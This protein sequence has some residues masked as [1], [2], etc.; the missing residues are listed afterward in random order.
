VIEV[1]GFDRDRG[2]LDESAH[3]FC[4]GSK[5]DCRLTTRYN[6]DDFTT[7]LFAIMHEAGHG[8]YEQ[9]KPEMYRDQPVGQAQGMAFHES[10][11]LIMECQAGSSFEFIEF[12]AKLLRDD[13]GLNGPC[14]RAE[15]LYNR[16]NR[17]KPSFIRVEA[18]EVSYP[19]HVI[20]RFEIEQA[21]I[22]DKLPARDIPGLWASKMEQYLG[23]V[24]PSDREGCL[25]DVH[26]PAGYIG[27]FP[28][29]TNGAI[30]AS[31]LMHAAQGQHA[32]LRQELASGNFESLN[33]YLNKQLR[34]FGCL[35]SPAQLL[36]ISTGYQTINPTIF[37]DYL[38][39]KYLE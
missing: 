36:E 19:L 28:S 6:E 9:N 2:R 3:P 25:Q 16:I 18:D 15:N 22:N 5:D 1:M 29:Y 21:I 30:I 24:P 32:G 38:R 33:R 8:L 31:M 13:F 23:I 26:W 10:Q 17:V 4:R 34:G 11:S 12:L 37:L 20:L 39:K 27:Y 14:Y 35:Y 7:G